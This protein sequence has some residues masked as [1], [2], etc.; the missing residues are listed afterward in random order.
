LWKTGRWGIQ[1]DPVMENGA[2]HA[3]KNGELKLRMQAIR[4]FVWDKNLC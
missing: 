2:A 4:K 1:A 3:R